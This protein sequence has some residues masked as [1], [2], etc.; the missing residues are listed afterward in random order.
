AVA[1][2]RTRSRRRIGSAALVAD[3]LHAR[4]DGLASLGVVVATFGVLLGFERADALVG[5]AITIAIL[6]T[7]W[8]ASRAVLHRALD[9]TDESTL[10]LIEAVAGAVEGV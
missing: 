10:A 5:L 8:R 6:I 2:C 7:L 9:G 1:S 3:G 4:V